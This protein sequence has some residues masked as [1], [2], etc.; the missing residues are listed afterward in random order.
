[1]AVVR[2]V[3]HACVHLR[4]GGRRHVASRVPDQPSPARRVEAGL[5][6]GAGDAGVSL[7]GTRTGPRLHANKR[8]AGSWRET[9]TVFDV[10]VAQ[11]N[12]GHT[13][14]S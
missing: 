9:A 13:E 5:G 3:S 4:A 2:A 8:R 7:V 6:F 11:T 10:C 12:F 1:M 14:R